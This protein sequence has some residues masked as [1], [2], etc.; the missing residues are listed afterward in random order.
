MVSL[1]FNGIAQDRM[2][3]GYVL[4][5]D[6]R[7]PLAFV[8]LI[9]SATMRGSTTDIDGKF[10]FRISDKTSKITC[11]YVGYERKSFSVRKSQNVFLLKTTPTTL[12]EF[13][14]YPGVNPAH[15][16]IK[17]ACRNRSKHNPKNYDQY[18]YN[19]YNKLY[20][21]STDERPEGLSPN[22]TVQASYY[23]FLET[24]HLFMMETYTESKYMK[25][26][27]ISDE[28]KATRVSGLKNSA[29]TFLATD[30]QPFSFYSDYI[31]L[32]DKQY[33]S[34][35]S[36]RSWDRYLFQL[37]ETR[38]LGEDTLFVI[39]YQPKKGANFEG[40]KGVISINSNEFPVVNVTATNYYAELN[41]LTIRQQYEKEQ[42]KWF[43][44]QLH[45]DLDLVKSEV[46][47]LG[48]SYLSEINLAPGLT[49]NDF[50]NVKISIADS[51]GYRT[52]V[53]WSGM[54][55]DTLTNKDLN[56]Y[57]TMD[58]LGEEFNADKW[59]DWSESLVEGRAKIGPV[60][61]DLQQFMRFN[62]FEGFRLGGGLYT[63]NDFLPWFSGGGYF[64]YGFR[65]E[66]SKYGGQITLK[67]PDPDRFRFDL[68]YSFD[69][70]IPGTSSFLN[71]R[72]E[73]S[74]ETWRRYLTN[75]MN[76]NETYSANVRWRMLRYAQVE[77]GLSDQ[78][79]NYNANYQYALNASEDLRV[80]NNSN[81]ITE[82]SVRLR[83]AYGEQLLKIKDRTLSLGT[84]FPI[85]WF[86]YSKGFD[87][88]GAGQFAYNKFEAKVYKS[89][90]WKPLGHFSL[91]M[92]AGSVDASI[93]AS[94]L[95]IGN[96][97]NSEEIPVLVDNSFQTMRLFEFLSTSY[98][99]LHYTHRL[100]RVFTNTKFV[101]PEFYMTH[102]A[103]WGSILEEELSRHQG[104]ALKSIGDGY[105]ESGLYAKH[106]FR[107]EYLDVGFLGFG[108][109]VFY[110]YGEHHLPEW[111]DNLTFKLTMA[112]EL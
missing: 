41:K 10:S 86:N 71:D 89:F 67:T 48:R 53:H 34:P 26:N 82:A 96:G 95:F 50:S 61:F 58:S 85:V 37:E 59:V 9:D 30:L 8:T 40:L 6:S 33:I 14:V 1:S 42:G 72:L 88:F 91:S 69:T 24:H 81:K 74:S 92:S 52:D 5:Y 111:S 19:S 102:N 39:K 3:E 20:V 100:F 109:G 12:N 79:L 43:P 70:Q 107:M 77:L 90:T 65:D 101:R 80:F 27:R 110:R 55:P 22:D 105:F 44:K 87:D 23:D 46:K 7:A 15:R 36:N 83:F 38:I 76:Y 11:S 4:D 78:Y 73:N 21:T 68:K 13:V 25:P 99:N 56:T 28:V 75:W 57:H 51:A 112:F 18:T 104:V 93:P 47:L 94:H 66:T 35:L 60:D 2:L 54:R 45:F 49:R 106:L 108:A 63:N 32:L 97:T 64:A 103:M 98:M 29:F 17:A 16:I 84:D 62:L 31:E